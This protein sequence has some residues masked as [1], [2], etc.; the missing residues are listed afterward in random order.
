MYK[1]VNPCKT[2][3]FG[4]KLVTV[5]LD[6]RHEIMDLMEKSTW[7]RARHQNRSSFRVSFDY[8]VMNQYHC[9]EALIS[10]DDTHRGYAEYRRDDVSRLMTR[11]LLPLFRASGN[12]LLDDSI[13]QDL[14]NDGELPIEAEL[15]ASNPVSDVPIAA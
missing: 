6:H 11:L 9:W 2:D 5:L 12:P 15:A 3:E 13:S 10:V 1:I 8:R 14:F 7:R 4:N